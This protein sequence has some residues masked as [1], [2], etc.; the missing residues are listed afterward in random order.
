MLRSDLRRYH[1]RRND[2]QQ[3]TVCMDDIFIEMLALNLG[4]QPDSD[5]GRHAV[6]QWM[7]E[8]ID[9]GIPD[10]LYLSQWLR[11]K[12]L[13]NVVSPKLREAWGDWFERVAINEG[14]WRQRRARTKAT[15]IK[16]PA[17]PRKKHL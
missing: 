16:Q 5:E 12:I 6:R 2:G 15:K 7:Q 8:C 4:H 1:L 14:K 3:T 11:G 13:T 17:L 9:K 10:S